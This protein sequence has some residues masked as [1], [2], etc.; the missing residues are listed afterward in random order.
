[1]QIKYL[2]NSLIDIRQ[3]NKLYSRRGLYSYITISIAVISISSLMINMMESYAINCNGDGIWN[4]HAILDSSDP[5][6][7]VTYGSKYTLKVPDMNVDGCTSSNYRFI[8]A[9]TWVVFDNGDWL[10]LGV[11]NGWIRNGCYNESVYRAFGLN[12][13][14]DEIRL[15]G[16]SVGSTH[17]FEVSD[18]DKNKIWHFYYD[19]NSLAYI[20]VPHDN[21]IGFD[22]G[23]ETNNDYSSLP[24]THIWNGKSYQSNGWIKWIPDKFYEEDPLWVIDCTYGTYADHIHVGS[25]GYGE[26]CNGSH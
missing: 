6:W 2:I 8:L 25:S 21:A 10:E 24:K 15:A 3:V 13:V 11:A 17:T 16:T 19:N 14:Y 1:M 22:A 18:V 23:A 12:G 9:T 26:N 4:C 7:V 5:A 20:S